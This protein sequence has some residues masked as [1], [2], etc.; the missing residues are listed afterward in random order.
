[1]DT[2]GA[3]L[4][5]LRQVIGLVTFMLPLRVIGTRVNG[6]TARDPSGGETVTMLCMH[7]SSS[8]VEVSL[9]RF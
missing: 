3:R 6:E 1:M 8:N 5:W 4:E 2:W 9:G 7:T